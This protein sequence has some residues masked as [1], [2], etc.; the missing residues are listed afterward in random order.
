MKRLIPLPILFV[1]FLTACSNYTVD[2]AIDNPTSEPIVVTIDSLAVEVP[3]RQVVWVEMGEG[4]RKI[5]LPDNE[6]I[7]ENF[8]DAIYMLN[9][10]KSSYLLTEQF[11]GPSYMEDTYR[12]LLPNKEINFL[13]MPMEGNFDKVDAVVNR[14]TWDYGPREST[15][16]MIETEENYE[17]ILKL[18]DVQELMDEQSSTY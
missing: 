4:E 9:P 17:V 13:G 7:T 2:V 3:A 14:V 11:Y 16:N 18:Y 6:T 10:T 12:H 5:T 15:P 1:L 8:Q